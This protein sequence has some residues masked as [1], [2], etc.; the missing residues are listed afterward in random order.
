MSGFGDSSI[1]STPSGAPGAAGLISS[2]HSQGHGPG[3]DSLAG[4]FE[5]RR[6]LGKGAFGTVHEAFDRQYG[7]VVALKQ[8]RRG[9]AEALQLFKREFRALADI[10]HPNLVALY[11]LFAEKNGDWFLEMELI[12][13]VDFLSFVSHGSEGA[14]QGRLSASELQTADIASASRAQTMMETPAELA[15]ANTAAP[16]PWS[17]GSISAQALPIRQAPITDYPR[18]IAALRQLA[19]GLSALHAAGKLH[20]DVKPANILVTASARVVLLDFGLSRD[21]AEDE[22][23]GMLVGTPQYMSPEQL[24]GQDVGPASDWYSVGVILYEALTGRWPHPASTLDA[25][26]AARQSRDAVPPRAL[27]AAVPLELD[28]LCMQLLQRSPSARPNGDQVLAWLNGEAPRSEPSPSRSAQPLVGREGQLQQLAEALQSVRAGRPV[29]TLLQG[30]SGMGK[31]MLART[32]LRSERAADPG[33]LILEGRC[34]EQ[35]TV[36][37]KALDGVVDALSRQLRSGERD[38]YL[39][40]SELERAALLRVFP[41]LRQVRALR[42]CES[43]ALT[44][45]RELRDCAWRGLKHILTGLAASHCMVLFI[46]DL[47]WGDEDSGALLIEL[48]RGAAPRMLVLMTLRSDELETAPLL[49]WLSPRLKGLAQEGLRVDAIE[50]SSLSSQQARILADALVPDAATRSRLSEMIT[51]EQAGQAPSPFLITELVRYLTEWQGQQPA[52]LTGDKID[53]DALLL[54]RI[55]RLPVLAMQVLEVLA[56]AGRPVPRSIVREVAQ[57]GGEELQT[58][59]KLRV[60]HFVR[61]RRGDGI[62]L[63]EPYHDRIRET[64][65]HAIPASRSGTLHR[66]L[67]AALER[68]DSR[69]F[70]SLAWHCEQAGEIERAGGYLLQAARQAASA[71]AFE[72]AATLYRQALRIGT[73]GE[74]ATLYAELGDVLSASGHGRA[75]AEAFLEAARRSDPEAAAALKSRGGGQFMRSGYLDEGMEVLSDILRQLGIRFYKDARI[76]A[77]LGMVRR[78]YTE[79]RGLGTKL[80]KESECTPAELRLLDSLLP[81]TQAYALADVARAADV[82]SRLMLAALRVGE[83]HRLCHALLLDA[84]FWSTLGVR[85]HERNQRYIARAREI[86][87]PLQSEKLS[88]LLSMT[89]GANA[90]LEGRFRE[91]AEFLRKAEKRLAEMRDVAWEKE[92]AARFY[93]LAQIYLGEFAEVLAR[94]DKI[95]RD[96]K[97]RDDA[98]T[99][100]TMRPTVLYVAELLRDDPEAAWSHTQA[101][102]E[103]WRNRGF[104][105][106]H[107]WIESARCDILLYSG[108][109]AEVGPHMAGEWMRLTMKRVAP[110]NEPARII[111]LHRLGRAALATAALAQSPAERAALCRHV[112]TYSRRLGKE[113]GAWPQALSQHLHAGRLALTSGACGETFGALDAARASCTALGLRI[114]VATLDH[115]RALIEGGAAGTARCREIEADIAQ[116]GVVA[117]ARLLRMYLPMSLPD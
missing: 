115:C 20:R 46:D 27:H 86:A 21:A 101:A 30:L 3:L 37:Y 77:I 116:L 74:A 60:A 52:E 105:G 117:P 89:E 58:L 103:R 107:Y 44:D 12:D 36:P 10:A 81:L 51:H 79:I 114:H 73:S 18:L 64:V 93:L 24:R 14:G 35:E 88:V 59:H 13:G 8:L 16:S 22:E 63:L 9:T 84:A 112:D 68:A 83:P 54:R 80:R 92:V 53:A 47:Q 100:S 111:T 61:I 15:L 110:F 98:W 72:H 32:F 29:V 17:G 57:L 25:L 99:E 108:R 56:T 62:E 38:H 26:S 5:L 75:A 94:S 45:A 55:E 97:G 1:P 39:P 33:L 66:S 50:V 40:S 7:C 11:E 2:I 70:E 28:A 67:I 85:Y 19:S 106:Q 87:Q 113:Q 90:Y 95:L 91:S 31:T 78:R 34:Y 69:D 41:A 43:A 96:A 42:D 49:R 102:R 4:R 109:Y 65:A 104:H 23:R 82:E 6:Q 76:A 71:L 48:L